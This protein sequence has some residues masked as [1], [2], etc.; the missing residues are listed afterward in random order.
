MLSAAL[1]VH[2]SIFGAAGISIDANRPCSGEVGA[3]PPVPEEDPDIWSDELI[4][5]LQILRA[6]L[7]S[8]YSRSTDITAVAQ[9]VAQA[10]ASDYFATGLKSDWGGMT[11]QDVRTRTARVSELIESDPSVLPTTVRDSLSQAMTEIRTILGP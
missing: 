5:L 6:I 1:L 11:I 3:I 7:L 4:T 10:W 8:D 2:A 9:S